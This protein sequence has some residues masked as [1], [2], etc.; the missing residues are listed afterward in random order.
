MKTEPLLYNPE[1]KI[2][3]KCG[4]HYSRHQQACDLCALPKSKPEYIAGI[5]TTFIGILAMYFIF[6]L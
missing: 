6:Q 5:I 3:A 4:H 2:C 1:F